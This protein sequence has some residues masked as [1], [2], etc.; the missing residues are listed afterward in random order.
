[1]GIWLIYGGNVCACA[2]CYRLC[3]SAYNVR[4]GIAKV[5]QICIAQIWRRVPHDAQE[6]NFYFKHERAFFFCGKFIDPIDGQ[7]YPK[8]NCLYDIYTQFY[9]KWLAYYCIYTIYRNKVQWHDI[10]EKYEP[11]MPVGG[12][13]VCEA[14]GE[15][16]S[17][18]I[19]TSRIVYTQ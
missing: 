13:N 9:V 17:K 6:F 15:W 8:K 16:M 4:N 5:Y 18:Y 14:C 11:T 7:N 1:M 12:W 19:C 2:G 3:T 10:L